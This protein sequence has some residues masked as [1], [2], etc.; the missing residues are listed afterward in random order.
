LAQALKRCIG[1]VVLI[2]FQLLFHLCFRRRSERREGGGR[3]SLV[4]R[5]EDG[6]VKRKA[7]TDILPVVME[8]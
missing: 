3:G 6:F 5:E 7:P 4:A 8:L 1:F 2:F